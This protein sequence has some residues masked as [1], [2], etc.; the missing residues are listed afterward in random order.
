MRIVYIHK[1]EFHKRPPVISVVLIL[2]ELGFDVVLITRGISDELYERLSTMKVE[3]HIIPISYKKAKIIDYL[4]FRIKSLKI[5]TAVKNKSRDVIL[6]IEGAQ[7]IVSL[8]GK[9]K[10]LS[11]VLQIQELHENSK[12]QQFAIS[13]TINHAK[14]VF[15]PEYNR[16]VIYQVWYRLKKRPIVLYNKPYFLPSNSE[17][18]NLKEKYKNKLIQFEGKKVILYQG[19]ISSV[20]M[21]ESL[22]LAL[23]KMGDEFILL[24][25]GKE[26]EAG[27]IDKLKQ[28]NSSVV[29][30]K[31]LPA[32]DYL[33]FSTIAY[34]GYVCYAPTSLNNAYCAP[35]KI[36]EYSAF[37]LPMIGNDIPGLKIIESSKSGINVNV[38]DIDSIIKGIMQIDK[39]YTFFKDNA[40]SIFNGIDNKETISQALTNF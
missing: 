37:S 26:N 2:V 39:N 14:V 38:D 27:Y 18:Q 23:T 29:H 31:P 16:T 40:R 33:V 9:I 11:Y 30:I 8:L 7:T 35:N 1:A 28:I 19:G 6:W 4:N 34:I 15:M 13:K 17:L 25:V 5:I 20:R 24:M 3:I 36:N 12:V 10:N 32:P 21:L 22:A